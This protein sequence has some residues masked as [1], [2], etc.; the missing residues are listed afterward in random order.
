[1]TGAVPVFAGFV[2]VGLGV[3]GLVFGRKQRSEYQTLS[4]TETTDVL[5]ITP[6]PVEVSGTANP[7]DDGVMRAPFSDTDCLLAE[8]EI[9]EW[10]EAGK[11]ASWE[12]KGASVERVPFVVDD[13]TGEV[14][15]RPAGADVDL[16]ETVEETIEVG[17]TEEPPGPIR[18]FLALDATPE[19]SDEPLIEALDWGTTHGD[20][21]Y[22]QHLLT[23]GDEVYV[24]GTAAREPGNEWGRRNYEIVDAAD[25]GHSDAD[26]FLVS[27]FTET[28][29]LED[30]RDYQLYLGG[31]LFAV[32][33]GIGILVGQLLAV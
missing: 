14:L 24:H 25:D 21:R 32:L 18:E 1:M 20:R 22:H 4:G 2:L 28:E 27:D 33:L 11:H 3:A 7:A 6:G 23:P 16:D 12:T 17:A 29:L 5:S 10:E 13:G 9:E 30:R 19:P 31:G 8:W 15:V 26:L